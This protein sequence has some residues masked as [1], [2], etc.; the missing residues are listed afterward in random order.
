ME[1]SVI[2]DGAH[3]DPV[4]LR[5]RHK[6]AA[7]PTLVG[8]SFSGYV[9][10]NG[11]SHMS[12]W[13]A[14]DWIAYGCIGIAAFGL[15][16]GAV[17]KESPAMFEQ[18]PP[19]FSSPKWSFAPAVLFILGTIILLLR[20]FVHADHVS[21]AAP[22]SGSVVLYEIPPPAKIPTRLR[23]QFSGGNALPR[24]IDQQN[25]WRWYAAAQ[26][27]KGVSPDKPPVEFIVN[28]TL[29]LM[30]DR[31]VDLT[32]LRIDGGAQLPRHEVKDANARYAIIVFDGDMPSLVLEL[33]AEL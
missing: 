28:W 1:R 26:L 16:T 15:A 25:I 2:R 17:W 20:V 29:F 7:Q 9:P 13:T 24:E 5:K 33:S 22:E 23:I 11:E 30:F 4:L 32:Q 27:R 19:L 12:R 6:P 14:W 3:V 21:R 31:P 10:G 8:V 18:W